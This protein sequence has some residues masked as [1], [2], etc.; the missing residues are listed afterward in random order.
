VIYSPDEYIGAIKNNL[1]VELAD[2][3]GFEVGPYTR[4]NAMQGLIA[5][6]M[7]QLPEVRTG[8]YF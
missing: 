4:R 2:L 8:T 3:Y 5:I 7:A 1:L 6:K